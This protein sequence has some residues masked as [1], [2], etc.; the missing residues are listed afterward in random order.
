MLKR[1]SRKRLAMII[2]FIVV[3][4]SKLGLQTSTFDGSIAPFSFTMNY[5]GT[6]LVNKCEFKYVFKCFYCDYYNNCV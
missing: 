3:F 4:P 2:E 6:Y 1:Q 5:N